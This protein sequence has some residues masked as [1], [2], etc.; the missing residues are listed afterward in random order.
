GM[1]PFG[2]PE[3]SAAGPV[4]EIL[5]QQHIP[6]DT[7]ARRVRGG[8]VAQCLQAGVGPFAAMLAVAQNPY[9]DTAMAWVVDGYPW[10]PRGRDRD[11][12]RARIIEPAT[13]TRTNHQADDVEGIAFLLQ[14][15]VDA[16][17]VGAG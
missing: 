6:G 15:A 16:A 1:E 5:E 13:I 14:R 17:P 8:P 11:H 7:D 9:G 10:S 12:D 2:P 3:R 4:A